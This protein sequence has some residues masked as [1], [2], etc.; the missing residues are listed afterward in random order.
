MINL[1]CDMD[2]VLA[3][4]KLERNGVGRYEK[5]KSFFKRLKP[6][7]SN[8]KALNELLNNEN[9]NVFIL[10]ASPNVSAD[11]DKLEWLKK[12]LP[13][14]KKENIILMR[15]GKNKADYV[16]TTE[17]NVLVDDYSKNCLDFVNKGYRAYLIAPYKT[18]KRVLGL[19]K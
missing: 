9:Y 12:Y 11:N 1:Y 2:N 16:K 5:E 4:F 10:S 13:N 19:I 15:N 18:I 17:N 8:V 6:I 14:L 7:K 3:N